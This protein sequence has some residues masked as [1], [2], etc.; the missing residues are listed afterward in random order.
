M[1]IRRAVISLGAITLLYLLALVWSDS[2]NNVFEKLPALIAHLAVLMGF[3]L[4][5]YLLRYCRWHWLLRRAGYEIPRRRGLLAYLSGFAFTATP[6]KVG[7]LLRIRY[8]E[9]LGVPRQRVISAFIY[10]R[11]FDLV[12]VLLIATVA[13]TQ[14]DMF[15]FM[16]SFVALMVTAVVML[17]RHP[18]TIGL[19]AS[20]LSLLGCSRASRFAQTLKEGLQGINAWTTPT[21][22]GVSMVLGLTAWSITSLSFVWLLDLLGADVP[23]LTAVA[24]YPLAMLTGAATM[25]PGGVVSTEVAIVTMLAAYNIPVGT[26]ALAAVGIRLST[27]WFAIVCGLIAV[28][29]LESRYCFEDFS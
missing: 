20:Y 28:L 17:A 8:F 4:V 9:P 3:S 18:R 14:F 29:L 15:A 25:L 13:A 22:I 10:E 16:A 19:V 7:E 12:A 23:L 2:R 5:S 26:S 27:L 24:V 6:G 21:D 11:A 1:K